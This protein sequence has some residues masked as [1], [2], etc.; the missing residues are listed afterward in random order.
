MGNNFPFKQKG[1][2]SPRSAAREF[3][4]F[5]VLFPSNVFFTKEARAENVKRKEKKH[6]DK[7]V[8]RETTRVAMARDIEEQEATD[9]ETTRCLSMDTLVTGNYKRHLREVHQRQLEQGICQ[10]I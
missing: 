1:K 5:F 4:I 9:L 8:K 2:H 10:D 3:R 7:E 6:A